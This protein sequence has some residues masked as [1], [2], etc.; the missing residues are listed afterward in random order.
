MSDI[1]LDQV[2]RQVAGRPGPPNAVDIADS[3]R[4]LGHVVTDTTVRSTLEALR[5]DSVGAGPL[6]ALLAMPGVTD[7][8]VNGPNAVY[9]DRGNGLELTGVR[10]V[11]DAQVRRLAVRIAASAGRRL[12]DGVPCV[13]AQLADGTRVHALLGCLTDVGTVVSLRVPSAR[14]WTLD[15]WVTAGSLTPGG[16]ELLRRLVTRRAALLVSGGTGSGKTTLLGALLGEVSPRQRIVV[17]EDARELHPVHPHCLR[18]QA[19]PPNGEGAGAVTMTDLVR[20]ALRMRPDR[21]VVGEVRGAEV[22]DLLMAMNTG[23]EGGAGTVHANSATDVLPRLEALAALGGLSRQALH[24]QVVAAL[25]VVIHVRREPD[26]RRRLEQIGV[27]T[28]DDATGSAGIETAVS[29]LSSGAETPGP[30]WNAMA[31]LVAP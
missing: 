27:L 1:D 30:G 23:H 28:R 2:R 19:R 16:A 25:D 11:D 18:L 17:V 24:A 22:I 29:F 14:T 9:L 10:F 8:L 15:D 4:A 21:L 5:R 12:D 13:D 7:V 20:Q 6:E 31:R 26:G 3:L